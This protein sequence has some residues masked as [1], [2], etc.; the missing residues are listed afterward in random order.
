MEV[1]KHEL[2]GTKIKRPI[3]FRRETTIRKQWAQTIVSQ[4]SNKIH[5]E[6]REANFSLPVLFMNKKNHK[7]RNLL[8]V[9]KRTSKSSRCLVRNLLYLWDSKIHFIVETNLIPSN[10]I[11]SDR[12][13]P[14]IVSDTS[15][16]FSLR[17]LTRNKIPLHPL[18]NPQVLGEDR[19]SSSPQTKIHSGQL[20][21]AS[22][23]TSRPWISW[24][25]T[26]T[27]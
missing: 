17:P 2:I 18:K 20:V 21:P 12:L 24:D 14:S 25:K 1:L 15:H 27:P 11:C 26:L 19:T 16:F 5:T 23:T 4:G 22:C 6:T 13:K 10:V 7:G 8:G 3:L 9:D